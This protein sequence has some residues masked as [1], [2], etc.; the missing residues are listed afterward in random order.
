[1]NQGKWEAEKV[2]YITIRTKI[3][4]IPKYDNSF[5]Q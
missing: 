4:N 2:N 1:M 5:K 3:H